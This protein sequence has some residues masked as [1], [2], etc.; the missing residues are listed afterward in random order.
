MDQSISVMGVRN[1]ALLIHFVPR[2]SVEPIP[3]PA[4]DLWAK[5]GPEFD[6]PVF[7]VANTLVVSDKHKT[8]PTNYNL[9][10]VETKLAAAI[11]SRKLTSSTSFKTPSTGLL[12]TLRDVADAFNNTKS[13]S[14]QQQLQLKDQIS[15]LA[16]MMKQVHL[17]L[18]HEPYSWEDVALE[19]GVDVSINWV[20][21]SIIPQLFPLK[22][23][24]EKSFTHFLG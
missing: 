19:L 23:S 21:Q 6:P 8:A 24:F 17:H 15:L 12:L 13:S 9:R 4:P 5:L 18:K 11:L 10:V 14:A 2:L 22:N 3:I 7:V 20:A 16:E 1:S